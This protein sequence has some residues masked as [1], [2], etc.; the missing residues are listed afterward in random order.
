MPSSSSP[1][2]SPYRY[3]AI[4]CTRAWVPW[5]KWLLLSLGLGRWA[6]RWRGRTEWSEYTGG[7]NATSP[8]PLSELKRLNLGCGQANYQGYLNLDLVR[9]P[10]LHLQAAG[11]NLPFKSESFDEILCTDVI[12]H[13][14][15]EAG[16][17]LLQ[18]VSR[19]LRPEGH[20]I[21]VTP[22]L[23]GIFLAYQSRFA[24]YHQVI[25]HLLGD[26]RDH[27]YLYTLSAFAKV[28]PATGLVI[29]RAIPHWGPIW[30]HLALLAKKL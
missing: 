6:S 10:H 5:L 12:E 7:W 27:R 26:A 28:M 23:D 19:V 24:T 16:R 1:S 22:D 15:A 17:Q 11:Q 2:L 29:E 4:S 13:L 8:S 21:L 30:A 9:W 14:G 20:L 25:Q 3:E 18:E